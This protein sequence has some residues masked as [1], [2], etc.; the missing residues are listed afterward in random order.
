MIHQPDGSCIQAPSGTPELYV[1]WQPPKLKQEVFHL[2][3]NLL[4]ELQRKT[5]RLSLPGPRILFLNHYSDYN[6]FTGRHR[7]DCSFRTM[8]GWRQEFEKQSLAMLLA[9]QESHAVFFEN[10]SPLKILGS[11]TATLWDDTP[12]Q[13]CLILETP[14]NSE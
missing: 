4:L 1:V 9:C 14:K 8:G 11:S 12:N 7:L 13:C 3:P 10:Y 5:W 6:R 2:F